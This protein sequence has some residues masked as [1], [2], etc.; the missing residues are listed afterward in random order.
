ML[1]ILCRVSV[2]GTFLQSVA[3]AVLLK[4]D[5]EVADRSLAT[6]GLV[7]TLVLFFCSLLFMFSWKTFCV[8]TGVRFYAD[9]WVISF[10]SIWIA[11]THDLETGLLL[12]GYLLAQAICHL[13]DGSA[14]SRT[15]NAMVPIQSTDFCRLV[16]R[17][18]SLR[19]GLTLLIPGWVPWQRLA[20]VVTFCAEVASYFIQRLEDASEDNF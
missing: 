18:L 17:L 12:V 3:D 15:G 4:E 10:I 6:G 19:T 7:W 14:G 8:L 16:I 5:T 2:N 9:V 13:L 1:S 11:P 20:V